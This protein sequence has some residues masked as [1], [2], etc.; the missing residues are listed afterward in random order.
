MRTIDQILG[1]K[2]FLTDDRDFE[3]RTRKLTDR[4]GRE[5]FLIPHHSVSRTLAAIESQF[6]SPYRTLSATGGF[7]P[8]VAGV[9]AYR[10]KHYVPWNEGR[11][12][13]TSSWVDNQAITVECANLK[14][15][16]PWPVGSTGK[17]LF[18]ELA[19]AMHVEL[20][21]PLDRWQVADHQEIH[22]RGWGS[23]TTQCC[24]D[25]LR[26]DLDEIVAAAKKI[27]ADEFAPPTEK[28][29]Q[30]MST[31]FVT[32]Q[33]DKRPGTAG[34]TGKVEK[35]ALAG[36]GDGEAAWLEITD[37]ALANDLSLVHGR[38]VWLTK[39][40]FATWKSKYLPARSVA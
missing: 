25:D 14:L 33:D 16:Y 27:V 34:A 23:Y 22:A 1:P 37:V 32:T 30:N 13:T 15:D 31:L 9:D 35:W 5:I 24:G 3:P 11:P 8:D 28:R 10:S 7:G 18:A 36:D 21:M 6:K 29:K 19:A 40:T 26:G 39:S 20:G 12:Y 2:D 4:P 38:H 17:S